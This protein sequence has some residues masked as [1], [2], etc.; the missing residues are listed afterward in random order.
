MI[1]DVEMERPSLFADNTVSVAVE[2]NSDAATLFF[3]ALWQGGGIA[4]LEYNLRV[5]VRLPAVTIISH[6]D[7]REVTGGKDH[8]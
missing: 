3:E 4:A 8:G 7:A 2:W 5:P 1:K 6:V